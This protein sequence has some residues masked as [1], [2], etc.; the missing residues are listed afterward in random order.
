MFLQGYTNLIHF[1]ESIARTVTNVSYI[2]SVHPYV[3]ILKYP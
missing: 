1:E 2:C 3:N